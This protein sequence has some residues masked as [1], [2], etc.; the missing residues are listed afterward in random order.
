[1]YIVPAFEPFHQSR[2]SLPE[3]HVILLVSKYVDDVL[4]ID[5]YQLQKQHNASII[6]PFYL[7]DI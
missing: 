5:S 3:N 7:L 4:H 6:V 1:V 2:L